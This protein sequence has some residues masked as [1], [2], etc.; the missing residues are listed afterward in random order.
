MEERFWCA[1]Q[2]HHKQWPQDRSYKL[3]SGMQ[4]YDH[5]LKDGLCENGKIPTDAQDLKQQVCQETEETKQGFY[6][7]GHQTLCQLL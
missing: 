5:R 4:S 1:V 6:P 2:K 7:R 3:L